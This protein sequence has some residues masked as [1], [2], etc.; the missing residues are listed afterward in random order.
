MTQLSHDTKGSILKS[1]FEAAATAH[2][3]VAHQSIVP[4][5]VGDP[6]DPVVTSSSE[7]LEHQAWMLDTSNLRASARVF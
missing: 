1:P 4:C 3:I 6:I 5:C 7:I 2:F